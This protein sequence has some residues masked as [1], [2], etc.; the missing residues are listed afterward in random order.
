[1][2]RSRFRSPSRRWSS[3]AAASR[4]AA[5]RARSRPTSS[6]SSATSAWPLRIARE[7][8]VA[9]AALGRPAHDAPRTR[10]DLEINL[11]AAVAADGVVLLQVAVRQRLAVELAQLVLYGRGAAPRD[12]QRHKWGRTPFTWAFQMALACTTRVC[13]SH[14]KGSEPPTRVRASASFSTTSSSLTPRFSKSA[15]RGVPRTCPVA[16]ARALGAFA[17]ILTLSIRTSPKRA[18]SR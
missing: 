12:H 15:P 5:S 9:V 2:P 18:S 3:S 11:A 4:T 7:H 6:Y 17:S 8:A 16:K 13:A 14:L 10:L 1:T